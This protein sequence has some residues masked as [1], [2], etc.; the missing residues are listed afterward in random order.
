MSDLIV[1]RS[2]GATLMAHD[3]REHDAFMSLNPI[4]RDRAWV[5][6]YL[7][8]EWGHNPRLN[9]GRR[10][11]SRQAQLV[12]EGKSETMDSK[13]L[14]G[15]AW[16]ICDLELGWDAPK[17]FWQ[18]VG[19]SARIVGAVWGGQWKTFPDPAHSQFQGGRIVG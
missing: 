13:H 8:R 5:Q 7:L 18:A 3:Q 4:P 1:E 17:A 6:I 11:K 9:E 19:R 16:D 14:T 12:K 2:D 15:D 10:K